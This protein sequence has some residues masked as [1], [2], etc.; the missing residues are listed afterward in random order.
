MSNNDTTV[1]SAE[2]LFT[3]EKMNPKLKVIQPTI[4]GVNS[5]MLEAS[6][7][8]KGVPES[9]NYYFCYKPIFDCSSYPLPYD[10]DHP[11]LVDESD[12]TDAT[13]FRKEVSGLG[14]NTMYQVRAYVI[15]EGQEI[16]SD[17][18]KCFTTVW[19]DAVVTTLPITTYSTTIAMFR[20]YIDK[21]G[22]SKNYKR[23]FCFLKQNSVYIVVPDISNNPTTIKD[24]SEFEIKI[25]S[26]E[27]NTTYVVR[28][29][30]IQDDGE[31]VYDDNYQKFTTNHQITDVDGNSYE[32]IVI[33][34]Q[35]WMNKN[36][37]VTK[38]SDGTLI[39]NV[40]YADHAIEGYC[41]YNNNNINKEFFGALYNGY[42]VLISSKKVCPTGWHVPSNSDWQTLVNYYGG[43]EVAG[44]PLK[45]DAYGDVSWKWPNTGATNESG[46]GFVGGGIWNGEFISQ[47][48]HGI[49]WS[50]TEGTLAGGSLGLICYVVT[51]SESLLYPLI[52]Q[53]AVGASIRCIK[54]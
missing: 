38:F 48:E 47:T 46:L 16:Y 35:V 22:T 12:F 10:S 29:Y 51:F 13:H 24:D 42:T 50:S 20:G 17:D 36:L 1:Y 21:V 53:K 43:E 44:G 2:L 49:Y 7:E 54:D 33:G 52:A 41:W 39:P 32:G 31:I 25:S 19:E 37:K 8:E 9:S 34:T 11:T 14:Y 26:L 27:P 4:V 40:L 3:T 5:V 28:A 23:G 18:S 15:W 45:L 30:V 6:I